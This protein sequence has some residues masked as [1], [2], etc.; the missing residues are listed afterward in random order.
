LHVDPFLQLRGYMRKAGGLLALFAGLYGVV[1]AMITLI[2]LGGLG[3]SPS[4]D[5]SGVLLGWLGL[6]LSILISILGVASICTSS[7][8]PVLLLLLCALTGAVIS[9]T[10]VALCMAGAFVSGLLATG[11]R[12]SIPLPSHGKPTIR[13]R[14]PVD[15]NG[16][17]L[18]PRSV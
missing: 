8:W 2:V 12:V 14:M 5:P 7:Q 1:A 6:A 16:K 4:V 3:T 17:K 18:R 9:E 10:L 15:Y 13:I 11:G